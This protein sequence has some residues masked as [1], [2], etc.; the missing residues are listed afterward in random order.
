MD[1]S[2][3]IE[4]YVVVDRIS[5]KAFTGIIPAAND[6]VA[7][8]GF[9]K[10]LKSQEDGIDPRSY[11]LKHIGSFNTAGEIISANNYQVVTGDKAQEF[12]D[13]EVVKA[14]EEEES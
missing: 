3:T 2:E 1:K 6:L 13:N 10:W 9:I 7:V 11:T 5:K 8:F 4:L 14:L 12:Y